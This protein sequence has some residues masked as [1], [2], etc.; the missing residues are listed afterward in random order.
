MEAFFETTAALGTIASACLSHVSPGIQ[1]SKCHTPNRRNRK[2]IHIIFANNR[3]EDWRI[4][5][6]YIS[7]L[8]KS[9]MLSRRRSSNICCAVG[10]LPGQLCVQRPHNEHEESISISSVRSRFGCIL[11]SKIKR[12]AWLRPRGEKGSCCVC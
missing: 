6:K 10:I 4:R 2:N 9:S 3:G 8:G 11:C 5:K 12:K 7:M 1:H